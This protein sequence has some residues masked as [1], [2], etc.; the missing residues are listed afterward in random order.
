MHFLLLFNTVNVLV[1]KI[2]FKDSDL[3]PFKCSCFFQV[4]GVVFSISV[5]DTYI[6]KL[7]KFHFRFI[8]TTQK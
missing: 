7:G 3:V 8:S 2:K 6:W 4:A 1:K 5:C